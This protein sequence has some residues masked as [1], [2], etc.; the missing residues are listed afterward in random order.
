MLLPSFLVLANNFLQISFVV[1]LSFFKTLPQFVGAFNIMGN[2][3][4]STN[5]TI[6]EKEG[7]VVEKESRA[8]WID[9]GEGGLE[10]ELKAC[11]NPA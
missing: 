10:R 8:T 5:A 4:A 3:R 2:A 1:S 7:F 9:D 6:A 11:E